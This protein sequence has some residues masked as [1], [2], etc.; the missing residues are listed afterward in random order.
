MKN[1]DL[2][3]CFTLHK[4]RYELR[5]AEE[6]LHY[7]WIC[8][9]NP[10]ELNA[11]TADM[12]KSIALALRRASCDRSVVAIVLTGAGDR[13]FSSGGNTREYA[14]CYVGR[15]EEYRQYLRLFGDVVTGIL[16][17]DKPVV[18]R[19]NG[20][21]VGGGQEI[22]MACDFSLAQDLAR[23]GQAGPRHGSAPDGGATD[24]L[25]LYVGIERAMQSCV[26][27]ET[28][29]AHKAWRLGLLTEIV[30]ALRVDGTL[31]PSPL[32][33]T[34]RWQDYG[35]WKQGAERTEGE[36]V[37]ARGRVDLGPLDEA[38]E[39]LCAK[40]VGVFP[41]CAMKTIGSLRK[42]K[43]EHWRRN[44]D[45]NREWLAL[46]MMTEAR[47]GFRA[48][49]EGAKGHR[50]VDFVRLRRLLAEGRAWDDDLL[51]EILPRSG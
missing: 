9:D 27:C 26:L 32:C 38:V 39:R 22:G 5:R 47:A 45:S 37:I 25:H 43:L 11:Y 4:V 28:W 49:H 33:V 17:A 20:L 36:A 3:D 46:N 15:P 13:A 23:F 50:E 40:L 12:L 8:L 30:P 10:E 41:G 2:V 14:E 21:R 19:V 51:R 24:F 31:V 29:S 48:F 35:E 18:C 42:K 44:W 6:G 16:E 7:A 34:D 1:H